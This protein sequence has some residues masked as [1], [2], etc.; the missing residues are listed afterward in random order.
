LKA[1]G[2]ED[3]ARGR[4]SGVY[5]ALL[6]FVKHHH[7]AHTACFKAIG[8]SGGRAF[9]AG[10]TTGHKERKKTASRARG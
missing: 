3:G 8:G 2:A 5:S 7:R 9:A 6:E 4:S 1:D 10:R